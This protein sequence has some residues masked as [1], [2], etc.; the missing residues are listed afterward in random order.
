MRSFRE[1]FTVC[2]A[3]LC[4]TAGLGG[5]PWAK[6]QTPTSL[7]VTK[8]SIGFGGKY[9]SGFWNPIT[10]SL[11]AGSQGA[12]GQ[13][14]LV[15]PDGDHAPVIFA[16]ETAGKIDLAPNEQAT[17]QLYAKTG[18]IAS[19]ITL[20]L[21]SRAGE[22]WSQGLAATPAL[23]ATQ[24]LV[25][26]IGPDT[27]LAEA[28]ALIKRRADLALVTAHVVTAAEL[29]DAWWG[30]EGVDV[31]V[32]ATSDGKLLG[33]ISAAQRE[34]LLQWVLQGGRII[35]CVGAGGEQILAANSPWTELMP[36][37][38]S[39]VA[40][41]RD[42]SGLKNFTATD[43][44]LTDETFQHNRPLAT[45]LTE[46]R[47]KVLVEEGGSISANRPLIVHAPSGL[48][49][50]IFIGLD[51][52]HPAFAGWKG[53]PQ[54][55][56][57]LLRNEKAQSGAS[58]EDSRRSVTHL[59]YEDL[60]GQLRAALDQFR[61]VTMVNFTMVSILTLVYLV[62]VGPGDYFLFRRFGWP[63][64]WT[65]ITF[66]LVA[67]VLGG[68]VWVL[69]VQSHG[70]RV[71]VNQAEIIDLDWESGTIRGTVWSHIYTPASAHFDP[72]LQV[73]NRLGATDAQGWLV[74]QGLPGDS[75]GGLG[76]RQVRLA[77][78]E[79][80]RAGLPGG[81]MKLS[82]LPVPAAASKSL[83]ARWWAN[84]KIPGEVRLIENQY[85]VLTGEFPFPLPVELSDCLLIHG[86]KLYR[87][88][89]LIPGQTVN[90]EDYTPL[91]LEARLTQRTVVQAKDI[92]K[93]WQKDSTDV[94]QIIQMMMLHE[95][96]RG[97]SY[98]GLTNRYP[99]TID[100]TDQVR[101]GRAVLIGRANQRAGRLETG[102]Q[103]FASPA[104]E[105]T[106]TWYRVVL[107]VGARPSQPPLS[108]P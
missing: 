20:R 3:A 45:R 24:E 81:E 37:K 59:G 28:E 63:R 56:A 29:P 46:T 97:S 66:P 64:H 53:R 89:K 96:A 49:Q 47:G 10:V 69:S 5:A 27:G 15:I 108:A 2:S 86:E 79:P 104:D 48:G 82:G 80:Y 95:A 11:Q 61:G 30:Y 50:V 57:H 70:Q 85:G 88:D 106:W 101:L 74:W 84:T 100:L 31:V 72:V 18:P 107:P 23:L 105:Q 9:K 43:L 73:N 40:P 38:L 103:E 17:I 60:S 16:D 13:L 87:L 78:I 91:N 67:S 41:L 32:L 54:L 34:A 25:V 68:L 33:K 1:I 62:L 94:P 55:L 65:W 35:V 76:S 6:G 12:A 21:R 8:A 98:T 19:P 52:D 71:R 7:Q 26:G 36:G 77:A 14:E 4:L 92:S 42:G 22:V 75:L 51:L 99:P 93:Q 39:D 83:T 102:A 90:M 58:D 44:P